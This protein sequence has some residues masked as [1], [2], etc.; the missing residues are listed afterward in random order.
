M[1]LIT[2]WEE[3]YK[4]NNTSPSLQSP[5]ANSWSP[6]CTHT[7]SCAQ[8]GA[9]T[10]V[11]KALNISVKL[12]KCC[13]CTVEPTREFSF[14][15]LGVTCHINLIICVDCYEQSRTSIKKMAAMFLRHLFVETVVDTRVLPNELAT[16][17]NQTD[18]NH[19][20]KQR[21]NCGLC[22]VHLDLP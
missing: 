22:F 15:T 12:R 1:A 8:S 4:G 21:Q 16:Q 13:C 6:S 19:N 18:G 11:R 5:L 3:D 20:I 14:V 2:A 9:Q 10:C 7:C 17:Q